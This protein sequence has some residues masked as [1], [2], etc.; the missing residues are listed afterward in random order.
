MFGEFLRRARA[1][2]RMTYLVR[3]VPTGR[4]VGVVNVNNIVM[5][6]FC[7]AS[8]GYYG[9]SGGTG[10]GAMTE[11]VALAL[12]QCF[13]ALGLHRVEVNVQPANHASIALVERLG[14][15]L[16]GFSPK[17]LRIGGEWR[18]HHRYATT[19]EEWSSSNRIGGG[20]EPE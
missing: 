11:G 16:E 17:M 4:L 9:F 7:S 14:L 3:R 15:R 18:D 2:D 10:Q 5:G 1:R 13:G 8:L 6:A 19:V 20:G 12:D